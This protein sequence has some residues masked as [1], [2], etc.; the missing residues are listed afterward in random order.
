MTTAAPAID[1]SPP[2]ENANRFKGLT[3]PAQAPRGRWRLVLR[4][5]L[6]LL[7]LVA[8]GA[9]SSLI[10][11]GPG[12]AVVVTEFG[13]PVRVLTKPGLA[14]KIPAPIEGTIPVDLRLRTTSSGLQ[15][16]GTR[17]GL[18]VLVQAYIAWQVDNDPARIVQFLRAGQQ[19][20]DDVARQL[21][22]FMGSTLQVTTS[23][24]NLMDLVNTDPAK[25][26][27]ADFEQA[28]QTNLY[29][30]VLDTYGIRIVQTGVERFSLPA[31]TLAATVARM[32][33]ERET[34]AAQRTA[35]GLR[36]AAAIRSDATRDARVLSARAEEQAADITAK[37]R[38]RAAQI[39]AAAYALDPQLYTLLRSLDTLDA[40]VGPKTRI[41]LRTDAAP[42]R[43]LVDG[44]PHVEASAQR[45]PTPG[46]PAQGTPALGTPA[47]GTPAQGAPAQGAPALAPVPHVRFSD[48]RLGGAGAPPPR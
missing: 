17:D 23:S 22:S 9:T 45:V 8:A 24:F 16:V 20:P 11:V 7:V 41:I 44:P 2:P 15:D 46:A 33:A 34:V 3:A 37:G 30:Q 40:T 29:H 1:Q 43:A 32:R 18:R 21:R 12:E 36:I 10:M 31:E 42:F 38:A 19:N 39:H 27:L 47:P 4:I 28:L 5:T 13:K 6:A 26:R 48:T 14:W 25:A 35:D